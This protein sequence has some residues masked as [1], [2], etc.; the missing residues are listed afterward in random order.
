MRT[1]KRM[2]KRDIDKL[3]ATLQAKHPLLW[4]GRLR[5]QHS[6][7]QSDGLWFFTHPASQSEVQ[8]ESA[9]GELPFH[10][11]SDR[12]QNATLATTMGQ[13]VAFIEACLDLP[14][15]SP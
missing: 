12:D 10:I 13:A 9:T 4:V 8:V 5:G 6:G 11:E 3:I 15:S 14:S 7:I 2:K 1:S